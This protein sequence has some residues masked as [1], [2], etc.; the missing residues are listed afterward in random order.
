MKLED[1]KLRLLKE[2]DLDRVL[3]WRNSERIHRNMFTDHKI[4]LEEHHRWFENLDQ[5]KSKYLVFEFYNKPVGLVCFTNIDKYN[6]ICSWG[7]YLGETDVPQ[8]TGILMGYL[9]LSWVFQ[10]LKI[11]KVCSKVFTY[12]IS[13]IKYHKK[14]GFVEEGR[15]VKHFKKAGNYED[16]I[17]LALF[18][19]K[20]KEISQRIKRRFFIQ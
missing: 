3:K 10:E 19:D 18:S 14:L 1:G 4:S 13:S 12:N 2:A 5:Q 9:A 17:V 15:L 20:W 16:I 7:F 6:N 11:R 8:G